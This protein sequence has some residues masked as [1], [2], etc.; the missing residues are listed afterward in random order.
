M[1]FLKQLGLRGVVSNKY[2][3][4]IAQLMGIWENSLILPIHLPEDIFFSQV[5][6]FFLWNFCVEFLVWN[7]VRETD[8]STRSL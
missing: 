6:A 8:Y 5:F 3:S 7:L 1:T 2:L 4:N